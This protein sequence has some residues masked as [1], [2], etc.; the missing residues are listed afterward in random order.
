MA[1]EAVE[2]Q[3]KVVVILEKEEEHA[4]DMLTILERMNPDGSSMW[5]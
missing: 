4:E 2:E 3:V 1:E 5:R